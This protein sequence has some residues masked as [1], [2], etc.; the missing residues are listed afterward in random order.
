M[1]SVDYRLA[2]EHR[3][4]AAA[5]DVFAAFDWVADNADDLG[6]DPSRV[7]VAGDSAGGVA[8]ADSVPFNISPATSRFHLVFAQQPTSATAGVAATRTGWNDGLAIRAVAPRRP[9]VFVAIH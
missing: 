6:I 8:P 4:P 2:P 3:A 5:E 9:K 7:L 1:V